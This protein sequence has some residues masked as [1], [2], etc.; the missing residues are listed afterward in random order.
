MADNKLILKN[1]RAKNFRSVGN[2]PLSL[3]Y[4]ESGKTLI[5][6][7]NNGSGKST[8]SIWALFF[9]L[10]G[11]PYGKGVKIASLVNSKSN[12]D[13]L[14]E[15]EFE[16]AGSQWL[17][18]RGYKPSIFE[19]YRDDKLIENEASLGDMQN[20]LESVIGMNDKAFSSI[21]A[22]GVD[23][24]VPFIQMSSQERR[25]FVE[26]ML[27]L[28]V[29]SG[30]NE[31]TKTKV[32][33][34]RK[35]ME[36]LNYDHGILESKHS[37]R[38]RTLT[39]LGDKKKQRLNESGSELDS[40]EAELKKT[41][42]LIEMSADKV[43][44]LSV[45]LNSD[46]NK[47]LSDIDTMLN[48]FKYRLDD[49]NKSADKI[50]ELHD[51]PTCKQ[52][53]TEDHKQALRATADIEVGKLTEPMNK[54]TTERLKTQE[55]IDANAVIVDEINRVNTIKNQL[56]AKS[57]GLSGSIR[58]IR[59]KMIDSNEDS[60]IEDE[61]TEIAKIASDI[62]AKE[63]EMNVVKDNETEHMQLLQILKDDGI[64]A[65]IVAQYIPFLNQTINN[66]LDKLNLYVQINIDSE[67]NVIM[68]APDRKNQSVENLSTGQ[69]RKIDVA[70]LIAWREIAKNKASVDC[71]VLILDEIL[72]NFSATSVDEFME[73]WVE[74]GKSTNLIAISQRAA[75]FD[76]YFDRTII[77]ALKDD[78]TVEV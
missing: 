8:L 71:N 42:K 25:A 75:E 35:Q 30:M 51:C 64:K 78:M 11:K 31:L 39:I 29:I 10:F 36:Q 1:I 44:S 53:V 22:L 6:S 60:L 70:I 18:K 40:L 15:L 41:D 2:T 33:A 16:S 26:Q 14:V 50:S 73:M 77:Y 21:V 45:G 59:A 43:S 32:K 55:I 3:N 4:L 72:E 52:G 68:F 61:E 76:Q 69:L 7:E 13:C 54:L 12:K 67:F 46:A 9:V 47:K 5:I 20:Y 57:S 19:I 34:I 74:V 66:I 65:N 49:I 58:Q 17:V 62:V 24:F 27:D 23:K 28:I 37:G 56:V 63:T 48:R 38:V